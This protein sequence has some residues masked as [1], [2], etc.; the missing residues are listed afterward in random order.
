MATYTQWYHR[1]ALSPDGAAGG[2]RL[3]PVLGRK[4]TPRG[5]GKYRPARKVRGPGGVRY[6]NDRHGTGFFDKIGRAI[7]D[8]GKKVGNVVYDTGKNVVN[9]T[10][11]KVKDPVGTIGSIIKNPAS[12]VTDPLKMISPLVKPVYGL[13]KQ[14]DRLTGGLVNQG[15]NLAQAGA[16]AALGTVLP[17]SLQGIAGSVISGVRSNA[18]NILDKGKKRAQKQAEQVVHQA[19]KKVAQVMRRESGRAQKV[20]AQ[21]TNRARSIANQYIPMFGS[22]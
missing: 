4:S 20:I 16:E 8:V 5:C 10:I 19:E 3:A 13:A 1:N 7:G 22:L 15:L 11:D 6:L 12:I 9:Q 2:K 17:A 18:A 14:A 21:A